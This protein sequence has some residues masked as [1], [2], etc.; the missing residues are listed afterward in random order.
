M[1][2]PPAPQAA[3]VVLRVIPSSLNMRADATTR[4]KVVKRLR[5]GDRVTLVEERGDWL[6]ARAA[7]GTQG[8]V[9]SRFLSRETPCEPDREAEV[10]DQPP[11]S[12]S[13]EGP[14][15]LVVIE[16]T[17]RPDGT[18]AGTRVIQN[19]SG[20][21]ELEQRA[22]TELE[23]MRFQV[24]IRHCKPVGFTYELRRNY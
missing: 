13:Q 16:A 11:L 14:H 4:A 15:G 5:R 3:P 18:I 8:W 22:E 1:I 10:L 20:S 24:P 2:P 7:D 9:A 12:F 17:V 23:A 21:P 19:T 6:A